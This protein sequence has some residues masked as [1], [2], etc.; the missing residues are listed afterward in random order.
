MG[1]LSPELRTEIAAVFTSTS[2]AFRKVSAQ[3]ESVRQILVRAGRAGDDTAKVQVMM[4]EV[5]KFRVVVERM[6]P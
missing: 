4:Q 1:T 5:E 3:L 2:R 6:M